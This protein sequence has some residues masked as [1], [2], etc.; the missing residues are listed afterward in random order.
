MELKDIFRH[1]ERR[2]YP[3][4]ADLQARYNRLR[5]RFEQF[6]SFFLPAPEERGFFPPE[7]Q[8]LPDPAKLLLTVRFC[9]KEFRFCFDMVKE[10]GQ[11]R[12]LVSSPNDAEDEQPEELGRFTFNGEGITDIVPPGPR[13]ADPIAIHEGRAAYGIVASFLIAAF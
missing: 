12:C 7:V 4:V 11:V 10:R 8:F 9:G 2:L 3:E 1:E 5:R 13:D 6:V